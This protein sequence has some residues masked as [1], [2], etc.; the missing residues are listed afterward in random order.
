MEH[1]WIYNV[2]FYFRDWV[3]KAIRSVLECLE[4]LVIVHSCPDFQ[5]TISF[6][7]SAICEVHS[8]LQHCGDCHSGRDTFFPALICFLWYSRTTA[9]AQKGFWDVNP[10]WGW[11]W[12]WGGGLIRCKDGLHWMYVFVLLSSSHTLSPSLP[13]FL[14]PLQSHQPPWLRFGTLDHIVFI[15]KYFSCICATR[16]GERDK[17]GEG[18]KH[19]LLCE[20]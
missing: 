11:Q 14:S 9:N 13:S 16:R 10:F 8:S 17:G 4:S 12:W 7:Q 15:W 6:R 18:E 1:M 3:V 2:A 20:S 19:T 5:G